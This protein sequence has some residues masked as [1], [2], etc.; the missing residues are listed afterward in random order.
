M[1]SD[2]PLRLFFALPC[3]PAHAEAIGQWR[4]ALDIGGKP[5]PSANFHLTLAFLGNRPADEVPH[6]LKLAEQVAGEPFTLR[7]DVLTTIGRGFACLQP[8]EA[9]AALRQLQAGLALRLAAAGIA[10]DDRPFTPHLTLARDAQRTLEC[11]PPVFSWNVDRFA[12]Y[13]SESGPAGVHYRELG[14]WQLD[15]VLNVG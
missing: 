2:K 7:L 8:H 9:P 5:V 10:L 14:S 3:P 1:P 4:D 11:T 12:L 13:V 6:L 15:V